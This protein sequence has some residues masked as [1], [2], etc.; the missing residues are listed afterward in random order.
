M[1]TVENKER[2]KERLDCICKAMARRGSECEGART[3]IGIGV[4][5]GVVAT[6]FA[7]RAVQKEKKE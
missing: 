6:V 2:E 7:Q 4:A 1:G 5:W 3:G